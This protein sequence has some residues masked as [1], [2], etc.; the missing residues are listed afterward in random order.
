M[1]LTW[2][3]FIGSALLA[4]LLLLRLGAP[5]EAVAAGIGGAAL[6]VSRRTRARK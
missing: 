3:Y 4:A 6:I 1:N 5:L 2:S